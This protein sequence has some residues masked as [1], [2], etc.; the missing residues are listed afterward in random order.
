MAQSKRAGGLHL[1]CVVRKRTCGG[2]FPPRVESISM[3][4]EEH[5]ALMTVVNLGELSKPAVVLIEKIAT[6]VGCVFEPWQIVRVAKA[7]AKADLIEAKS[8]IELMGLR[9]RA[10][11]RFISEEERK[12][13][14]IESVT[15]LALP[16]LNEQS[17]PGDI[18]DDWLSNLFDKCRN[19]SDEEMQGIW[20]RILAGEANSPRSFSRKTVN[21]LADLD[22]HDAAL[23]TSLCRF[24]LTF[25]PPQSVAPF[26]FN[27]DDK[28]YGDCGITF[29]S[30]GHLETLGLIRFDPLT[31][32]V[33]R[34]LPKHCTV[35]YFSTYLNL[36]L[37]KDT[38]NQLVFGK[39]LL[40]KAGTELARVCDVTPVEGFFEYVWDILANISY[41]PKRLGSP[42]APAH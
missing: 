22:K 31:G 24:T 10:F 13:E 4:S 9:Q 40:T 12:Q 1:F 36:A 35:S 17:A 26:V 23:F 7:N 39:T 5:N 41:V 16:L 14:N 33:R 18:E 30:L 28:I 11:Q 32:F 21:L 6:A 27:H 38:D 29:M 2:E 8:E 19:I 34:G 20:A 15:R 3:S 37:P 42:E 25:S